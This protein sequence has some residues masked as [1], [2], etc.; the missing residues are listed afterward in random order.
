[1]RL[2]SLSRKITANVPAPTANAVQFA[3]SGEDRL[4]YRP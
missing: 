4:A 2:L 1:M 3:S